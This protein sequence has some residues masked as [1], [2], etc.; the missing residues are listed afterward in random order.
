MSQTALKAGAA[1]AA[2]RTQS[3]V[4]DEILPYPPATIWKALTTGDLIGRWMMKPTGFAA[5]EGTRFS[6]QTTAA[7]AWDGVIRCQIVEVRPMECF[8]YSWKGGDAANVG[9]GSLLDTLV[10]FTLAPAEAGTRLRVVHSGFVMPT[11]DTAFE[12]MS[13][14][15]NKIVTNIGETIGNA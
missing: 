5:V 7:G 14:G 15:W 1:S 11:N 10:T 8:A 2:P 12:N 3:I 13:K 6:F 4:V 9:Y